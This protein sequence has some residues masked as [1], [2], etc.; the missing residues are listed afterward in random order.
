MVATWA[1][2]AAV[3]LRWLACWAVRCVRSSLPVEISSTLRRT[4]AADS[5]MRVTAPDSRWTM[6]DMAAMSCPISSCS[7]LGA[8]GCRLPS[9]TSRARATALSRR[10][11]IER[12]IVRL[13]TVST[14][15]ASAAI[16]TMIQR[17]R[18]M[19]ASTF[20]DIVCWRASMSPSSRA[21]RAR[22]A[23]ASSRRSSRVRSS[24]A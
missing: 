21:L 8:I 5:R 24:A 13:S 4:A 1:M 14:V 6:E 2:E 11:L 10:D 20:W 7:L 22:T 19:P 12:I 17:V 18:P 3:S 16:V 23:P 15:I 9:A